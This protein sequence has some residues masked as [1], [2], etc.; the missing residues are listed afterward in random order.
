MCLAQFLVYNCLGNMASQSRFVYQLPTPIS[1]SHQVGMVH[2]HIYTQAHTYPQAP[3]PASPGSLLI[4]IFLCKRSQFMDLSLRCSPHPGPHHTLP[5]WPS[6]W[7][8]L[9]GLGEWATHAMSLNKQASVVC[10]FIIKFP[11]ERRAEG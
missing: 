7:K 9:L 10:G 3:T 2:M 8:L 6:C 4:K 11:R 5:P 1:R